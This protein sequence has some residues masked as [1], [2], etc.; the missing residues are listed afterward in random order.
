MINKLLL[1]PV[2]LFLTMTA[3]VSTSSAQVPPPMVVG[4]VSH[5][6]EDLLRFVPEE[7]DWVAVVRDT[8]FGSGDALYSGNRGRAELIIPN[9]AWTRIG[10]S[11]QI[12]FV[13]VGNDVTEADVA[14]GTA[15]FYNKGTRTV[16]KA[17]CPFGYVLAYPGTVFDFYVGENS[18]EVVALQGSVSFIHSATNARYDVSAGSPSILADR[19]Q[20][21]AGSGAPDGA[22]DAWNTARDDF[23]ARK[24]MARGQSYQYLPPALDDDAY[25]LDENGRWEPVYYEGRE[26]WFWRPTAV[27]AGWAPFTAGR[28]T[29]WYGDQTWIPA[30]PFGYVTHHY[31][32]WVFVRNS[33]YWA[34]PVVG[35]VRGA[36]L[37]NVAFAWYPG[38]V[39][40]IYSDGY[41]GWVPLAPQ[42][43]YYCH[44]YWGG[45]RTEVITGANINRI[46]ISIRSY[47]YAR[48]AVVVNQNNFYGV[49]NY[50]NVRVTNINSTTIINN[51][52]A[53][54][55]VN[56]TVVNNYTANRQR[57]NYANVQV[58]EKPHV[59]VVEHIRQNEKIAAQGRREN[60][61]AIEQQ[62]KA[63][64]VGRVNREAAVPQPKMTNYIVPAAQA[65]RPKSEV[66][67]QQREVKGTSIGPQGRPGT[68][69]RV[70]S[71]P[72]QSREV[73]QSREARPPQP[74]QPQPGAHPAPGGP[75]RSVQQ[76]PPQP[77]QQG[78]RPPGEPQVR[79]GTPPP[80]KPAAPP[81]ARPVQPAQPSQR[82]EGQMQTRPARPE[83]PR[84]AQAAPQRPEQARPE[85]PRPFQAAPPRPEQPRPAQAA[86][87][88][89]Q[90]P[91]PAQAAPPRPEQPRPVQ[92]APP[93]PAPPAPK[94][95]EA[96]PPQP[97]QGA[98]P[99]GPPPAQKK[100]QGEQKEKEQEKP[101]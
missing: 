60:A 29:E 40:W 73:P 52:R 46:N 99:K 98:Q 70:G 1:L 48:H 19:Q 21:G 69:P 67:L 88:R 74:A 85:Q 80:Q 86:P 100:P 30:E 87:A 3:V 9:G 91:H 62:V 56:N 18:V 54:P 4:R 76:G 27:P 63:A 37:L 41:V 31:G 59:S 16:I 65:N 7:N 35:V 64:K 90:Q 44:H 61:P 23:W 14:G 95:P 84:P 75:P 15:R 22:W 77:G 82:P 5:V 11:T 33:W 32:S 68:P 96:R 20:V 10:N 101:R 47:A 8:P 81:Q 55:V 6:E 38:R 12:Q 17:T 39:S 66:P 26:C 97:P 57:Y 49:N 43:V 94:P 93:R 83:G 78:Q 45:P 71:Q 42:E 72:S 79:P 92:A 58:A 50:R 28:W 89:P 34:P 25:T 36:P 24:A 2:L 51:Y 13:A 53:A